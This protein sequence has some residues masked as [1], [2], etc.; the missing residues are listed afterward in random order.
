[1]HSSDN[2]DF[3]LWKNTSKNGRIL[4]NYKVYCK[5]GFTVSYE[6]LEILERFKELVVKK[7]GKLRGGFNRYIMDLIKAEVLSNSNSMQHH[8]ANYMQSSIRADIK[9]KIEKIRRHLIEKQITKDIPEYVFINVIREATGLNDNR[10][11]KKYYA[12]LLKLGCKRVPRAYTVFINVEE[13]LGKA[14]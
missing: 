11:I 6:D 5:V 3:A 13:F 2:K 9:A 12:I 1:M 8:A 7:Y 10:S 4:V 14:L